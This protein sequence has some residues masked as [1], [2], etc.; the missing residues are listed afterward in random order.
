MKKRKRW[1]LKQVKRVTTKRIVK[2]VHTE[3]CEMK[4]QISNILYSNALPAKLTE[5]ANGNAL[6]VLDELIDQV[7]PNQ[8]LFT[9]REF[10]R[11][12]RDRASFLLDHYPNAAKMTVI[13]PAGLFGI[14]HGLTAPDLDISVLGIGY[15]RY[16]IFHSAIGLAVLRHF[17]RKWNDSKG[18]GLVKKATGAFLGCYAVGVGI[19]LASDFFHPKAVIFP[20]FGS[21]IDGTLIDDNIWLLG[22][23]LWAFRIGY[24]VF[25]LTFGDELSSAKKYIADN[26]WLHKCVS[27]EKIMSGRC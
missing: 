11:H 23:S 17:Y 3:V 7:G 6:V 19:H 9:D 22:N 13:L 15:H 21:L 25:A 27:N 2:A 14:A 26:Y 8:G 20:F 4:D 24:D 1:A 12:I 16:F 10:F 18:T 5:E